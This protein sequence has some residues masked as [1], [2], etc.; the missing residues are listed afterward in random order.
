MIGSTQ[1]AGADGAGKDSVARQGLPGRP[2]ACALLG[3]LAAVGAFILFR[4]EPGRAGIYPVCLLHRVTGLWCPGCG[5]LRATH[6]LLHGH[7]LAALHFNALYVILLP[8]LAWFGL[9][10]LMGIA[11]GR[12]VHFE[13]R[14]WWLWCGLAALVCF[15]VVR[16]LPFAAALAPR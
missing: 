7:I 10:S 4:F 15:G 8:L 14:P 6:Q 9:R 12:P 13:I 5:A 3:L 1:Q 16:N 11:T 2:L